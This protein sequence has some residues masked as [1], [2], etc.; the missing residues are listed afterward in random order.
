MHFLKE[1][2]TS[3]KIY[4]LS[5]SRLFKTL[6]RSQQ[7]SLP[8]QNQPRKAS[9][10]P[11]GVRE[12][13]G[14]SASDYMPLRRKLILNENHPGAT[15]TRVCVSV[16]LCKWN[17]IN[18][19]FRVTPRKWVHFFVS[20]TFFFIFLKITSGFMDE[21]KEISILATYQFHLVDGWL[22]IGYFGWSRKTRAGGF[23][24]TWF[25]IKI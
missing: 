18:L 1:V 12:F 4:L 11:N 23:K 3:L 17:I 8:T 7:Q 9:H 10:K 5:D 13:S 16:R 20:I 6:I 19:V 25:S 22:V 14:P 2:E 15:C 24:K 21:K